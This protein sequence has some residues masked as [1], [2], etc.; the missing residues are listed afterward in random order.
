METNTLRF[1]DKAIIGLR[2]TA[3]ELEEFQLQIALGKAEA[4]D[5]YEEVK[6]KFML[7]VHETSQKLDNSGHAIANKLAG[8]LGE[9]YLQLQLGKAETREAFNNQK[10]NIF[11]TIHEIENQLLAVDI[12]MELYLKLN[13]ELKKFRIKMEIL[14]MRFE[15]GKLEVKLE[16]DTRREGFAK[17][18]EE[19][20]NK[21]REKE[22]II[23]QNW[24]YFCS[25]IN[26]AYGHIRKAFLA[27]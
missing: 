6:K 24:N 19:I 21:F 26:E 3:I 8:K 20:K 9:L 2:N 23:E 5:T 13:S 27:S 11:K 1:L 15:L 4:A 12:G 16:F 7:F 17:N 18:I 10:E 14:H 22:H 25:E